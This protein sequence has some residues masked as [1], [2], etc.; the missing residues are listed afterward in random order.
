MRP[1]GDWHTPPLAFKANSRAPGGEACSRDG[2][3][4]LHS[5]TPIAT[6]SG[7]PQQ[8]SESHDLLVEFQGKKRSFLI[9]SLT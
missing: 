4:P 6:V 5:T 2:L 7:G 1:D 9:A 3:D 8:D